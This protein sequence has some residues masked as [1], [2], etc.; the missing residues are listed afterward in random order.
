MSGRGFFLTAG[1]WQIVTMHDKS[2]VVAGGAAI[3]T[4]RSSE[5]GDEQRWTQ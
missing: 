2:R 4:V 5:W 1:F 3:S